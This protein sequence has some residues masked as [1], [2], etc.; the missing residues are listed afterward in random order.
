MD[1]KWGLVV[2]TVVLLVLVLAGMGYGVY[3]LVMK[4]TP[5]VLAGWA[6]VARGGLPRG[7]GG[8]WRL[9]L[10]EARGQLE[11]LKM[12]L[13]TAVQA[14]RDVADVKVT[15]VRAM[16]QTETVRPV[17]LPRVEVLPRR[18]LVAGGGDVVEL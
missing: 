12:G 11:G 13:T 10:L 9:G 16:R 17:E 5:S 18:E 3:R 6:R 2:G 14:G 7:A 8:G 15:A 4:L 1:R